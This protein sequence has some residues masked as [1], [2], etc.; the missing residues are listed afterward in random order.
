MNQKEA[1]LTPT[2]QARMVLI[3]EGRGRWN[4]EK[5]GHHDEG[6]REDDKDGH[7]HNRQALD[8]GDQEDSR[9]ND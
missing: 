9:E 5:M 2:Q 3:H 4:H 8:N 6:W 1:I 7:D